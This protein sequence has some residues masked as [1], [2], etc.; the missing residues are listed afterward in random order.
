M[1]R[2]PIR[3]ST[4]K[5]TAKLPSSASIPT[6]QKSAALSLAER[7]IDACAEAN[8]RDIA[9]LNVTGIFALADYF[10][11]VSGKSDRQV[12]GISNKVL[13]SLEHSGERALAV[14]GMDDGQWVLIDLGDVIVHVFYEPLRAHYDLES[15]W[16]RAKRL[17]VIRSEESGKLELSNAA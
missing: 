5:A 3:S 13:D 9:V 8:G 11:V 15:L 1:K 14:E 2:N 12:Q 6:T 4:R 7:V 16:R 17:D 10:V